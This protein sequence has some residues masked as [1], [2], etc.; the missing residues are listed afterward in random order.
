MTMMETSAKKRVFYF[1]S[2][3]PSTVQSGLDLRIQGHLRALLSSADVSVFG[4][5]GSGQPCDPRI[6]FWISSANSTV[7]QEL[8]AVA[9]MKTLQSGGHP[10][11]YRFSQET[12]DELRQEL[13]RFQ[14]DVVILSRID[15]TVYLDVIRKSFRGQ[16]ILDLDESVASTGPSIV[17]V[18][19]HRGQ[20]LVLTAFFAKVLQLEK[21]VCRRVDQVWVSSPVESERVVEW[22]SHSHLAQTRVEVVPNSVVVDP[23]APDSSAQRVK[24]LIIYPASFAY[25]PSLDA[26]RFLIEELMPLIPETKLLFVGS[27]IP[28]WMRDRET[29]QISCEGPVRDMIPYF[30]KASAIVVPLRAGGG[31]RLKVIEALASG[32]PIISTGF[33]VEGLGLVPGEDYL[34]AETASEFARCCEAIRTDLELS[35]R[36]SDKGIITARAQFSTGALEPRMR[37]LLSD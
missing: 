7:A 26:A 3:L 34:Q 31:T 23:Y 6:S 29:S 15:L 5:N 4:L 8:D 1:C 14:P 9:G 37:Q 35:A 30:H 13:I 21:E 11:E 32:L 18:V 10:F 28:S 20:I 36:L 27:H 25:E 2:R 17:K 19:K 12:A 24:D 22:M 33:G 16:V